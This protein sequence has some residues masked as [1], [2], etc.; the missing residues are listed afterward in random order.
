MNI[1]DLIGSEKQVKWAASVVAKFQ[2]LYPDIP[3]PDV[4]SAQ[5]WIK[6][7]DNSIEDIIS[8]SATGVKVSTPFTRKY[9]M[10][11]RSDAIA[12]IQALGSD[13]IVIDL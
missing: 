6:N 2:T 8:N 10:F 1:L 4:K 12:A 3:L 11:S 9:P 5:W 13:F 7:R